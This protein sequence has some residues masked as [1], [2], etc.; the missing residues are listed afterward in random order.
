[1]EIAV[2]VLDLRFGTT[3]PALHSRA[4]RIR[5]VRGKYIFHDTMTSG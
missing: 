4:V 2:R 3:V 1:M 5:V